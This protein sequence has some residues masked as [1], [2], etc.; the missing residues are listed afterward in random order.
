MTVLQWISCQYSHIPVVIDYKHHS[1]QGHAAE[2]AHRLPFSYELSHKGIPCQDAVLGGQDSCSSRLNK[3]CTAACI[4]SRQT[5]EK[6]IKIKLR[7]RGG[8]E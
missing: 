5:K 2:D 8:Q 3:S 4:K 6:K 1:R 7:D